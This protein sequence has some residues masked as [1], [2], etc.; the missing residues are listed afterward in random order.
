MT[1][2]YDPNVQRA[3]VTMACLRAL[4]TAERV[5]PDDLRAYRAVAAVLANQQGDELA[6]HA[7]TVRAAIAELSQSCEALNWPSRGFVIAAY[8][9]LH[10]VLALVNYDTI[11]VN[12][13]YDQVRRELAT[14]EHAL[15]GLA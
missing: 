7:A 4:K 2:L 1:A 13:S 12:E 9:V 5:R 15:E 10:A 6:H 3:H 14:A 11:P 8:H